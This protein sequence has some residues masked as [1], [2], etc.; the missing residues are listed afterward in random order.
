MGIGMRLESGG[1]IAKPYKPA[2]I[3]T[4]KAEPKAETIAR[5]SRKS[6]IDPPRATTAGQLSHKLMEDRLVLFRGSREAIDIV[7]KAPKEEQK[8]AL[9]KLKPTLRA[10]VKKYHE[11]APVRK[12]EMRL[13]QAGARELKQRGQDADKILQTVVESNL[14]EAM[15]TIYED[16]PARELHHVVKEKT[17]ERETREKYEWKFP[18]LGLPGL[19]KFP[20]IGGTLGSIAKGI[21]TAIIVIG[22]VIVAV[23][24]GG[25]ILSKRE[26]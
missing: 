22:V 21:V 16:S 26:I 11:K 15:G 14:K 17:I 3:T 7:R 2:I 19:P 6:K 23:V 24:I 9:E 25:K 13:Y 1:K 18:D 8:L 4:P 12:A 20:D 5:K 10:Q